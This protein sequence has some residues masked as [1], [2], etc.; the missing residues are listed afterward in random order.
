MPGL[1][2]GEPQGRQHVRRQLR[3]PV[4]EG[5][6]FL[7]QQDAPESSGGG[8]RSHEELDLLVGPEG[9]MSGDT[10]PLAPQ[11][12]P[13][14]QEGAFHHGHEHRALGSLACGRRGA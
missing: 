5:H 13:D 9:V 7:A 2:C 14:P 6:P 11:E 4:P 1:P 12:T 10:S 8:V 3:V